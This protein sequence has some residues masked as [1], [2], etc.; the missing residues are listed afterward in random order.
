MS[1]SKRTWEEELHLKI[2]PEWGLKCP[3]CGKETLAKVTKKT[4]QGKTVQI[5]KACEGMTCNYAD[6][7]EF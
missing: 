2:E 6:K 5:L 7:E 4:K 1:K 3:K